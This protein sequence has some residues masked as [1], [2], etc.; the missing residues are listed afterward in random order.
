MKIAE[1]REIRGNLGKTQKQLASLLGVSLKTIHSYEQGWRPI[2]SHI[3]RDLLYLLINQNRKGN[4]ELPCWKL[5]GCTNKEKC[6]AWEFQSGTM[7]WYIYST[8]CDDNVPDTYLE[9]LNTC[10]SC[11]VFKSL[12]L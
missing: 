9:K 11:N 7:C 10:R 5:R 4:S 2:P 1:F 8:P 12:F 6:P 3:L